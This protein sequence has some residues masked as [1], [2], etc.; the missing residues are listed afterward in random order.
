MLSGACWEAETKQFSVIAGNLSGSGAPRVAKTRDAEESMATVGGDCSPSQISLPKDIQRAG[1]SHT[2]SSS[3]HSILTG[4]SVEP[5][6]EDTQEKA[7]RMW[8]RWGGRGGAMEDRR[9]EGP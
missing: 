7:R 4:C 1:P 3:F 5:W 9:E 2:G 6:R 8:W